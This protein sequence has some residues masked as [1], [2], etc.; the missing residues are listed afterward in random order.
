M[1]E[2]HTVR[3]RMNGREARPSL[4]VSKTKIPGKPL[5]ETK[6]PRITHHQLK[7][8]ILPDKPITQNQPEEQQRREKKSN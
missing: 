3:T 5:Q 4:R 6:T 2:T 7:F 1:L 8:T